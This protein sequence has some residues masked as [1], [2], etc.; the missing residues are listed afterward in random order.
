MKATAKTIS[1]RRLLFALGAVTAIG[2]GV[3]LFIDSTPT[4][5]EEV[6]VYK[7]PS[8]ECCG[9]WASHMRRNGFTVVVNS[10]ED[11]D[12]IK[13]KAGIPESMESCHTAYV[14]GYLVEGHV[15]ASDIKRVLSE[16]LAIKGLAVPGMP[17]SAPGMDSPEGES[18]VVFAFDAKGATSVFASY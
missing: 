4:M 18:Y 15:P 13:R 10:V 14:G 12:P 9:R 16:R 8:C 7:D 2:G 6:V 5:A 1:R 3:A 17:S 11:M